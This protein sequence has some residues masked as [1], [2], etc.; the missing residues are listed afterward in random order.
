MLRLDPS[1]HTSSKS[2]M[3]PRVE[4]EGDSKCET[5]S[6]TVI[7]GLVPAIQGLVCMAFEIRLW[8]TGTSPVMTIYV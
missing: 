6:P 3:D 8:I 7:A 2:Y 1:I 4:P 5:S